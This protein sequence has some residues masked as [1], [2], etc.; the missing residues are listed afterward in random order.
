MWISD[1]PFAVRHTVLGK[2]LAFLPNPIKCL[3]RAFFR[4]SI[5]AADSGAK[6]GGRSCYIFLC[7]TAGWGIDLKI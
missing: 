4:L 2:L 7:T 5:C 1:M 6:Q 3:C